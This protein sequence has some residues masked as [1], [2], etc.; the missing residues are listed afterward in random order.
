MNSRRL[1]IQ[2]PKFSLTS[3]PTSRLNR[4]HSS[5]SVNL[6]SQPPSKPSSSTAS[7]K[8]RLDSVVSALDASRSTESAL[9]FLGTLN[10]GDLSLPI[11][12]SADPLRLPLNSTLLPTAD[13]T[14]ASHLYWLLQKTILNQDIFLFSA[15][16]PYPRLLALTY[17]RLVN[18]AYEYVSLHRDVGEAELKQGREIREGGELVSWV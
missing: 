2:S 7:A 13:P 9:E 14:T 3:L 15:P 4:F 17:C 18:R 8:A 5:S 6:M 10:F 16:G 1:F 12:T 11:H